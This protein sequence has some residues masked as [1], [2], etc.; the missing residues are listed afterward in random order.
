MLRGGIGH[1]YIAIHVNTTVL[2]GRV[3]LCISSTWA[4][5]THDMWQEIGF[6]VQYLLR[7]MIL[8][9][10]SPSGVER[11]PLTVQAPCDRT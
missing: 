10:A 9:R 4:S 11:C 6:R 2:I 7:S 5:D 8:G 1:A 3:V